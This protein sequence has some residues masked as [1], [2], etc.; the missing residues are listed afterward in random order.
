MINSRFSGFC[1]VDNAG[2]LP[3]SAPCLREEASLAPNVALRSAVSAG[4]SCAAVRPTA[5]AVRTHLTFVG[6]KGNQDGTMDVRDHAHPAL[7]PQVK[8]CGAGGARTHDRGI[9]SPVL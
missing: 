7:F 6:T 4:R 3:G 5:T 9:M 8:P 2:H 1:E